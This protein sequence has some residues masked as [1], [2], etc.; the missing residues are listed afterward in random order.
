MNNVIMF[1]IYLNTTSYTVAKNFPLRSDSLTTAQLKL[2]GFA[3]AFLFEFSLIDYISS[4]YLKHTNSH[5]IGLIMI[6]FVIY[7][8]VIDKIFKEKIELA[9][10]NYLN[11]YGKVGMAIFNL[12]ATAG[13]VYLFF[14]A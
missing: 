1:A 13:F 10:Q 3:L 4:K 7:H 12:V 11:Y 14:I 9:S 2:C 8:Y 5:W 6:L